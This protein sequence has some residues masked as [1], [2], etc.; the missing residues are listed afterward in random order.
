MKLLIC[1]PPGAGKGTMSS[2]ITKEYN[3]AHISTGEVLRD[4]VARATDLGILA[5]QYLGKGNLVPDELLQDI[6]RDAVEKEDSF[7]FDGYPRTV[8]QAAFLTSIT[9]IDIVL[10]LRVP[11]EILVQRLTARG[12]PDDTEDV[13][14]K[15]IAIYNEQA[16]GLLDFFHE[17]DL[18][19]CAIDGAGSIFDTVALVADVLE[20]VIHPCSD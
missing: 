1:G 6:I 2:F 5:Q 20:E 3:V 9:D 19:V 15:R 16:S 10:W 14:K 17:Q 4:H 7:I 8:P 12:R 11:E 18:R 13:V